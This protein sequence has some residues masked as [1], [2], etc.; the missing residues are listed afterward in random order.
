MSKVKLILDGLN[1][2]NCSMKIE[3]TIDSM[4]RV[5][6]A[7]MNF[8][9]KILSIDVKDEE[10]REKML[11]DFRK[12]IDDIEPGLNIIEDKG[13]IKNPATSN[14]Y[15]FKDAL[16]T[17]RGKMMV[18]G[19]IC[20]LIA[21][22]IEHGL[23]MEG[24]A[25]LMYAVAYLVCGLEVVKEAVK[26]ILKGNPLDENLLMT[27]ATVG[28]AVLGEY[29]EAAGVMLFYNIGEFFQDMAVDKS[30]KNI[31]D[32]MDIVPEYANLVTGSAV[33]KVDP[34]NVRVGD[35]I[36]VRPGEKIPLDGVVVSGNSMLDTSAITGE[37]V[38]VSASEGKEVTS[39]VIN[40]EGII[41]V[42]VNRLYT[43]STVAKIL[44]LVENAG[45]RKAKTE[46]FI[47]VFARYYTP[48]VVGLA[49]ILAVLPPLITGEPFSKWIFRG[50][51]F[52]V[53]SC[54]CA[55][56]LSIP[57]AYF[58]GI[59]VSSRH[60]VLVKGGNFLEV[61]KDLGA[62]VFDKTG[63]LTKG[64]FE[65][66]DIDLAD[67]IKE[68]D[69]LIAAYIAESGSNHPIAKSI[70]SYSEKMLGLK[71]GHNHGLDE[72]CGCGHD[73]HIHEDSCHSEHSNHHIHE[74][75][76]HSGHDHHHT[77]EDCCNSEYDHRHNHERGCQIEHDHH[78][79]HKD[80]G[81]DEHD[82]HHDHEHNDE[83]NVEI[84]SLKEDK[85]TIPYNVNLAQIENY[86]ELPARG[87][88]VE[89]KGDKIIVGNERLMKEANIEYNKNDKFGTIAYVAKNGKFL[90]SIV[91]SDKIK[92][93]T[94]PG[95][96]KLKDLGVKGLYM[97]TGDNRKAADKV[98][99]EIGINQV[100]SE[101]KPEDKV[102]ILEKIKE[103]TNGKVIFVG[104]GVNDAPV[105]ALADAGVAMGGVGSDAAIEA[106]DM[107]IMTD[108]I[109]KLGDAVV[110]SRKTNRIVKENIVFAL[111]VKILVLILSAIGFAGMWMAIFADVGVA[112][113]AVLNSMRININ[114]N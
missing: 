74:D 102:G 56:V 76:C 57:L 31:T 45:S 33:T 87:I 66:S 80:S 7:K 29:P 1:C 58:S 14:S 69:V 27:I 70:F 60:G 108:D 43:D 103:K 105:L 23:H 98:A 22:I 18:G 12:I 17:K 104:D 5:N 47:T 100:Y 16:K 75:S 67:G 36:Q 110:I 19:A 111:G 44:D 49:F 9:S 109:S 53:V 112:L 6:E 25:I 64:V 106:A 24:F 114:E 10:D 81:N 90:G 28:A 46:D 71:A 59:G 68:E 50:L 78:H 30:R 84:N 63:T 3:R 92:D 101:L 113:L 72:E 37:S 97:L 82:H 51:I 94:K 32:L 65:V 26:N 79:P 95:I 89:Y 52:L 42:K 99:S 35:V 34:K 20:Y 83:N 96:E 8:A 93:S 15:T 4:P 21:L 62:V 77:N 2:A 11:G 55:L 48:I 40:V 39:G 38:L 86:R 107:V 85:E 54:P 61:I 88:E 91:I 41:N 73:H 13:D